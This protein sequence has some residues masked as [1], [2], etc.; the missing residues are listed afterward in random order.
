MKK[1]MIIML[2]I[3][4]VAFGG[5]YGYNTFNAHM[6]AKHFASQGL[7]PATVTTMAAT[8]QDWQPQIRSI[9]TLRAR[10]G[11]DVVAQLV[12]TV[13]KLHFHSGDVVKKGDL[14]IELNADEEQARYAAALAAAELALTTLRRDREQFKVQAVSQ[15]K[16]DAD[17]ADVAMKQAQA[18]ELK[19]VIDKLHI[20]APFD[21]RIGVSTISPGQYLRRGDVIVALESSDPILV[22]F[23]LPQRYL[24]QLKVGQKLILN[25]DAFAG[26]EFAGTISAIDSRINASTR[27]VHVEGRVE[28]PDG[29]L[30]PGM[31]AEVHIATGASERMLTLPQTAVSYNAYG[32]TVFLALPGK[33][34][35]DGK[36]G[37]PVAEQVFVKTGE[38]RGD[39]VAVL[40]GI[41]EGAVV[42]TSGQMKL[43]NGTPLMVN[44]SH[45]PAF[46]A[47]PEPQEH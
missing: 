13:E 2:A 43:K 44:N 42:V 25:S 39:Q 23:H 20:V 33:V 4:G 11:V 6:M 21:G 16:L 18:A 14:L 22:D 19:A 15:A 27:T 47:D 46:D 8:F 34:S 32:S 5:I 36:P 30:L 12:G 28:N 10:E 38:T 26:R 9:G 24:A 35:E 29:L 17:K 41:Q 31:Y 40:S 37:L 3:I 45:T 1:R 7:P